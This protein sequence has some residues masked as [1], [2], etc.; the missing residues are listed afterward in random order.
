[1]SSFDSISQAQK[2]QKTRVPGPTTLVICNVNRRI[3]P[4]IPAPP[5]PNKVKLEGS[6]TG[7]PTKLLSVKG[8]PYWKTTELS[9]SLNENKDAFKVDTIEFLSTSAQ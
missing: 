9:G 4:A 8:V 7:V 3:N 2:S 5:A 1:M 6:G